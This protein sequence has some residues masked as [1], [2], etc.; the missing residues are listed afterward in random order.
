MRVG[1]R[2]RWL[3]RPRGGLGG[4]RESDKNSKSRVSAVI[5][6]QGIN[7]PPH[8]HTTPHSSIPS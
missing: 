2:V 3:L 5:R 8:P 7:A 6:Q 1:G 4:R